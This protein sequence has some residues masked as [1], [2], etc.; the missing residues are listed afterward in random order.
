GLRHPRPR[1]HVVPR[2]DAAAGCGTR[3]RRGRRR[4]VAADARAHHEHLRQLHR[5]G[6]PVAVAAH[7]PAE[8]A[9][10]TA[11]RQARLRPRER[12]RAQPQHRL[13][14]AGRRLRQLAGGVFGV[15]GLDAGF[16]AGFGAVAPGA[17]ALGAA[18]L[19]AAAF[20]AAVFAAA[21]PAGFTSGTTVVADVDAWELAGFGAGV[22]ST[23]AAADFTLAASGFAGSGVGAAV[24]GD[25]AGVAAGAAGAGPGTDAAGAGGSGAYERRSVAGF[26]SS[27]R[28]T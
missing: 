9:R 1:G 23:V 14:A 17:A 6:R 19:G 3:A 26:G 13:I 4:S 16:A 8:N 28:S 25:A 20:G 15:R 2:R 5:V 18:A 21:R 7:L 12:A 10:A 27:C 22:S 11:C 24:A